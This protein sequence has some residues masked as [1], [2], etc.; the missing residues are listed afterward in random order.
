MDSLPLPLGPSII[1]DNSDIA[2]RHARR[3]VFRIAGL[4]L[5]NNLLQRFSIVVMY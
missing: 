3:S 5:G 2:T 4:H 1:T